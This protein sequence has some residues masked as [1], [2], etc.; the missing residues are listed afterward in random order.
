MSL[1]RPIQVG[2][3]VLATIVT[4]GNKILAKLGDVRGAT[5]SEAA[6][7]WQ[8]VGFTSRPSL[9]VKD[10]QTAAKC[11]L[12]QAGDRD[13]CIGSQDARGIEL[14]GLLKEGETC[15]Y[16]AGP[17]G[18]SQGR[19]LYKADGSITNFTKEGNDKRGDSIFSRTGTGTDSRGMPDGFTW[20]GPWGTM[21]FDATGF[22]ITHVSGAC[23]DLGGIDGMPPPL[24]QIGSYVKIKAAT[25]NVESSAFSHGVGVVD[26]LSKSTPTNAAL[27]ALQTQIVA[28]QTE[29]AAHTAAWTALAALTGPIL[30]VMVQPLAPPVIAATAVGVAEVAAGGATVAASA[31]LAPATQSSS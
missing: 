31:L 30:G 14:Y 20:S 12:V 27:A 21:R 3:D 4:A 22:H 25:V 19:T 15:V 23:F 28:L 1:R 26:P 13:V 10:S 2:M 7:W 16:A 11:V 24:D 18:L 5:D 9:A 6:E 29:L 8:H 17:D